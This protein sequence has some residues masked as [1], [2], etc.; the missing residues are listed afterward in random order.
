MIVCE[1]RALSECIRDRCKRTG[2]GRMLRIAEQIE[3]TVNILLSYPFAVLLL[4]ALRHEFARFSQAII[5][6]AVNWI[7]LPDPSNN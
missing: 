6:G 1:N 2:T 3:F 4:R 5:H 7:K